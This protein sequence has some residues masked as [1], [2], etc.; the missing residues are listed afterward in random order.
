MIV[1]TDSYFRNHGK[2]SFILTA[3]FF[4]NGIKFL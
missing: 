4:N 1:A 2:N 3:D